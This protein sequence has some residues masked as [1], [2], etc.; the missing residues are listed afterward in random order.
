MGLKLA[1][2]RVPFFLVVPI[3]LLA[4]CGASACSWD[5]TVSHE[6]LF[7][8]ATSVFIGHIVRTEEVED[9]IDGQR[10]MIIEGAFRVVEMLKGLSPAGGK[11]RSRVYGPGIAPF[12]SWLGSTICCLF[13]KTI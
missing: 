6:E 9:S 5:R 8:R 11:I 2:R 13:M 12:R 1:M 4:I 7:A 3:L 10:Q